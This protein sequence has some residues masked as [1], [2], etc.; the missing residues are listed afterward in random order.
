MEKTLTQNVAEV[1]LER[2]L[3][4]LLDYA[5]PDELRPTLTIGS[6]VEVP[7]QK[8]FEKGIIMGFKE[9]SPYTLQPILRSCGEGTLIPEDLFAL[10]QWISRY[11]CTPVGKVLRQ[12]LPAP[13]R[14]ELGAKQQLFVSRKATRDHLASVAASLRNTFP[15]QASVLDVLLKVE[16]GI[17]LTDLLEKASVSRSPI[18]ALVKKNLVEVRP[19]HIDRSPLE[20]AEFFQSPPKALHPQQFEALQA[21][22]ASL[23]ISDPSVHLLYGVTGS[24]KTEVY[25]QAIEAAL[26]AGK[27]VILMVP[28]IALTGQAVERFRARFPNRAAIL[29]HRLSDGERYDQWHLLR[30]GELQVA[31][32]ARSVLF[33]PVQKLG[34]ILVDEEHEASYKASEEMPAIHA[35][36]MAIVRGRICKAPVVLGSATPSLESMYH[37]LQGRYQLHR[38]THRAELGAHAPKMRFIDM[39]KERE[40]GHSL[41]SQDLLKS[42]KE[43]LD[44][45]EQS[46]LYLNRRGYFTLQMCLGCQQPVSCPHCSVSMTFHKD[47][48]QLLC[49]L[50]AYAQPP[51]RECPSCKGTQSLRFRGVGTEQVERQLH[52]LLP[53][54]RTL[55]LD[56]D[57]TRHKGSHEQI[58]RQFGQHRADILIGTQMIAKGLHFPNVTLVGILQAESSLQ[59]PDFRA[60]ETTFQLITQ[61]SG[62]AGRAQ[63][64]GEVILQTSMPDHPLFQH[65]AAQDYEAFYQEEVASR[66]L[67]GF[68][69]HGRLARIIGSGS[70][71]ELLTESMQALFD[72]LKNSFSSEVE[73]YP[74]CP[75][76]RAKVKDRFRMQILLRA[77]RPGLFQEVLHR[78]PSFKNLHLFLDLDPIHT[79]F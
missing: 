34:L 63:L 73:V 15:A 26:A 68:P 1:A 52:K 32:G 19:L 62:R 13:I 53:E 61:V 46:L 24:G 74:P 67:A 37:A 27:G 47:E 54:A 43:R 64:P 12:I 70:E 71:E 45:R 2:S 40:R 76:G 9:R 28:E 42:L 77:P 41:F 48:N 20:N 18:D 25:L 36:D 66:E 7:L 44:R 49:H 16:K 4:K 17:L 22:L 5:I 78:I 21:I 35:R 57:T 50:C 79:F 6:L 29:H 39:R 10:A 75:C 14:K 58:L 65:A 23:T 38:L 3:G 55:R 31:I 56:A 8:R 72:L 33:A 30:K 11:Y 51:P 60:T 59:V 69:P